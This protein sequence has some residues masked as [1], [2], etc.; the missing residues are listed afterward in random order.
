MTYRYES[1]NSEVE[2]GEIERMISQKRVIV[3]NDGQRIES[4]ADLDDQTPADVGTPIPSGGR[5]ALIW[6]N[7]LD[8]V[9]DD[10]RMAVDAIRWYLE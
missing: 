6:E 3:G 2:P 5:V 10:G 7:E 1:D 4:A 9:N 8:S